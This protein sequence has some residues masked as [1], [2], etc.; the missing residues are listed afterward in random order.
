MGYASHFSSPVSMF[1]R[2]SPVLVSNRVPYVI[3]LPSCDRRGRN[4]EPYRCDMTV[5][6]PVSRSYTASWYCAPTALYIQSPVRPAYQMY[7][8]SELTDGL[9]I[10]IGAGSRTSAWPEPPST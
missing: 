6:V 2:R 7:R 5:F 10:F 1:R 9:V 3:H 4:A 8:P